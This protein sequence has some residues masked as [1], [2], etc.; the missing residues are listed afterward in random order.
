MEPASDDSSSSLIVRREKFRGASAD[1]VLCDE[2]DPSSE[3]EEDEEGNVTIGLDVEIEQSGR[4]DTS[5]LELSVELSLHT[6]NDEVV[7]E[8]S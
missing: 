1:V 4:G 3:S 6:K 7:A 5:P 8:V 2:V